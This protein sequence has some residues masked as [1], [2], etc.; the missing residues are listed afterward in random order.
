[1]SERTTRIRLVRHAVNDWLGKGKLPGWTPGIHLNDRGREEAHA[2]A[3]RLVGSKITAVYSSPLERACETAGIVADRLGLPVKVVEGMI[4]VGCGE[5]TGQLIEELA[6][7]D[8]WRQV[9]FAPSTFRFPGGETML[10]VQ[11]RAVTA[12]EGLRSAHPGETIIVVS[13]ADVIKA[14]TAYYVGMALDLFQRL[15]ISPASIT[16]FAFG[17]MSPYLL[18]SND[19]SHVPPEPVKEEPD[20]QGGGETTGNEKEKKERD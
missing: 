18:R 15:A 11:S 16:E 8:L 14:V 13:H 5:W 2:L 9:Q 3:E 10:E 20:Q 19:T 1:M 4:E 12:L 6:K 7:T 17:G